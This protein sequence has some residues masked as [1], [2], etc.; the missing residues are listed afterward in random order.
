MAR[1]V[2]GLGLLAGC[3]PIV[4]PD[5]GADLAYLCDDARAWSAQIE[6]CVQDPSCPGVASLQGHV[7]G[8]PLLVSGT[9]QVATMWTAGDRQRPR[10][11]RIDGHGA[12]LYFDYAVVLKSLGVPLEPPSSRTLGLDFDAEGRA[13]HL[14]DGLASLQLRWS[15]PGRVLEREAAPGTGGI[16]VHHAA[17]DRVEVSIEGRFGA[18]EVRGCVAWIDAEVRAQ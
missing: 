16:E 10:L 13:D 8:E 17:E 18:D 12:G 11:D 7:E 15:V 2:F 3:A 1:S 5:V 9:L 6:D 14:E 4:L